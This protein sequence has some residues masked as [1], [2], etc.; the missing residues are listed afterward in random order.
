MARQ[1]WRRGVGRAAAGSYLLLVYLFILGPLAIVIFNSFNSARAFPSAFESF[2]LQWY[3]S[4]LDYEQF[5]RAMWVSGRVGLAAAGLATL[6]GVPPSIA[7]VRGAFPGKELINSFFMAPLVIPQIA[8]SIALLQMFSLLRLP[9]NEMT[10]ILAHTVF[11]IPYVIRAVVASLHYVSPSLEESAMNL[12][13]NPLQT[14]FYVTLPLI[15]SGL[16][17][18]FVLS[19][20]ISFINVPLSLFLATPATSTLPIRVFAYMESRLD[21]L[22]AAIGGLTIFI[23]FAIV[24]VLEKLLRV[25]LIL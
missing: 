5:M 19:F 10:L 20:V 8:L 2:T 22:V 13:A 14:F 4:L 15:R 23:V 11:V 25:R 16:T 12:G 21:P 17:A 18:G 24:I 3:Q 9:L 7:F 6:L 1:N